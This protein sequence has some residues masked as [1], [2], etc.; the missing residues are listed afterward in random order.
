MPSTRDTTRSGI[1]RLERPRASRRCPRTRSA[2]RPPTPPTSAAPPRASPSI[3]VSTTPVTPTRAL[4]SPALL[5]ASCPVIASATNSRSVGSVTFLIADELVHQLVVD[6]QAPRR[7][8]DHG[9]EPEVGR[10]GDGTLRARHRIELRPRDRAP[11]RRPSPRRR[12]AAESPPAASRRW[13]RAADASP[14]SPATSPASPTVVVLPAP[15][16]PSIRMTRGRL[17]DGCRPPSA[18]PKSA[19]ISSRTILTTCCDGDRLAEGVARRDGVHRAIA[20]PVDE[21]LDDLEVDV[22]FE[23]READLAERRLDVLRRQLRLAAKR[24]EHVL[25]ACA[26]GIEHRPLTC[27]TVNVYRS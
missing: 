9:V 18:L 16:R 11:A 10:F 8:D 1:E 4:N 20:D 17:V 3:F 21:G 23:Q 15:W 13:R 26:E 19:T 14:A 22:G 2:R 7:V 6:V 5:I 24:L 25:Q 27:S 12:S